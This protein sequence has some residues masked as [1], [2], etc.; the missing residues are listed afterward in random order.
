[1]HLIGIF[2]ILTVNGSFIMLF[3]SKNYFLFQVYNNQ[4]YFVSSLS[5]LNSII[6]LG[7]YFFIEELYYK[8]KHLQSKTKSILVLAYTQNIVY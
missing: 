8:K 3:S 4:R 6:L 1:M 7:A 2:K 5:I